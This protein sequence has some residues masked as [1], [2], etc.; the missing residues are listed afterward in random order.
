[1]KASEECD[2]PPLEMMSAGN[3]AFANALEQQDG[4]VLQAPPTSSFG[5]P[6]VMMQPVQTAPVVAEICDSLDLPA[7]RILEGMQPSPEIP[8]PRA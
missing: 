7:T 8:P 5:Q 2:K 1:M 4:A 3:F 6:M